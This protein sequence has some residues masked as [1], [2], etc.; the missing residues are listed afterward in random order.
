ALTR[1]SPAPRIRK[2]APSPSMPPTGT[3]TATAATAYTGCVLRSGR[4]PDGSRGGAGLRSTGF[5]AV[6]LGTGED[7]LQGRAA[8]AGEPDAVGEEG[9]MRLD[10][11][12]GPASPG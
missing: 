12:G 2:G 3:R 6:A 8:A 9:E 4:S 11:R 5:R 1:S 10:G 7:R